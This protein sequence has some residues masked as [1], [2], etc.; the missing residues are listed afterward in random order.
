[1]AAF[2]TSL[3]AI[4]ALLAAIAAGTAH[5]SPAAAPAA[6]PEAKPKEAAAPKQEAQAPKAEGA[7]PREAKAPKE[8]AAPKQEAQALKAEG[9]AP[10]EAK[11]PKE[12]KVKVPAAPPAPDRAIDVSWLDLRVGL[13]LE[14]TAHPDS[15]KLY[16]ETIDVGEAEPRTILSGLAPYMSLDAV[17]GARVIVICNLPARPLA[18]IPSNGMVLCATELDAEGHKTLC[19]FVLPPAGAAVG[20]RISFDAYPGEAVEPNKMKKKKGFE[21]CAPDLATNVEGVATY[22]GAPWQTSAGV[23]TSAVKGGPIS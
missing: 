15:D 23:C 1:M 22:K 11:A 17:K 5:V 6:K 2:S 13:I 20:E 16:I 8:A 4:D 3:G 12:A 19:Q 14:A 9:A 10:R 18:G 7:A 21:T